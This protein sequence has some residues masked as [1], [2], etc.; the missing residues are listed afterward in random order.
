MN[1][2]RGKIVEVPFVDE[3]TSKSPYLMQKYQRARGRV[4]QVEGLCKS[5]G[6]LV[7]AVKPEPETIEQAMLEDLPGIKKPETIRLTDIISGEKRMIPPFVV[8]DTSDKRGRGNGKY[9][10][11]TP[12]QLVTMMAWAKA[13]PEE[14]KKVILKKYLEPIG[15]RFSTFRVNVAASKQD[16]QH[17]ILNTSLWYGAPVDSRFPIIHPNPTREFDAFG[18]LESEFYLGSE[19]FF[20]NRHFSD[21][22]SVIDT[23]SKSDERFIRGPKSQ[24]YMSD[25]P[26]DYDNIYKPLTR[27]GGVINLSK[28]ESE[29]TPEE[30]DILA[31]HGWYPDA[32]ILEAAQKVM[33]VRGVVGDRVKHLYLAMDFD[34]D[35]SLFD[36]N[37]LPS[38][39]EEMLVADIDKES[40]QRRL[41]RRAILGQ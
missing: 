31:E 14:A 11:K 26:A 41:Y 6:A 22:S 33:A 37:T 40:A 28:P 5:V 38:P 19:A 3:P 36:I 16:G 27:I 13:H 25:E 10:V 39:I 29:L 21:G 30:R 35:G 9:T 23:G 24:K 20:S 17:R 2:L 32:E 34:P 18:D 1:S 7:D 15:S 8:V 12:A 4:E